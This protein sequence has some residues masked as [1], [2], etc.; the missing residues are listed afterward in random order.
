MKHALVTLLLASWSCAATGPEREAQTIRTGVDVGRLS[1][2]AAVA[3]RVEL[4]AEQRAWCEGR[5]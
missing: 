1:C 5:P 3:K 4:T 2:A